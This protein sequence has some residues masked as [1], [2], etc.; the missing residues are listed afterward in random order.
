MTGPRISILLPV[1]NEARL[2]PAALASLFRQTLPDWELVAVDD[3]SSDATAAIL[4]AA[5]ARDARV[6]VLRQPASGL[7]AALNA[8]LAECRAP[9]VARMDGDDICHPE[10]LQ[11]QA[12]FLADHPEVTLVAC[13]VRQV[14]R[15]TLTDGM[16][17]YE[18]WQNSLLDHAEISRDLFVESPFVHPSVTFRRDAVLA[19]GGYRDAGWAEDYDLW[20][21]LAQA[22][23]RFARLA[24]V[25]FYWRDR[26]QRQTRT[27]AAYTLAAFRACK[28]H[29][30]QAGFLAGVEAVTLWGAGVEGKAWRRALLAAGIGVRRWIE[31]DPRKLGQTIHGAPVVGIETLSPS[32]GKTLVTVGTKGARTQVRAH[33]ARSGL[34]E[35]SDFVCVT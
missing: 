29:H 10:R 35:G 22:G 11:H 15:P 2:L 30:L 12:A 23:A 34:V 27:A 25:L 21:R 14:P 16:L 26:P 6:R 17:A 8:G 33:A 13:G 18:R 7:V 20:L 4:A 24:E 3:G 19:L 9:L 31:V 28:V 1:R 5:A 32:D